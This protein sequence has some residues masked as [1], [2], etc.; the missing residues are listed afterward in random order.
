MYDSKTSLASRIVNVE[1]Q[2]DNIDEKLQGFLEMYLEDRKKILHLAVSN[3]SLNT[4]SWLT[5][6]YILI[7]PVARI[8]KGSWAQSVDIKLWLE[9]KARRHKWMN[10]N[11]KFLL[12]RIAEHY[13]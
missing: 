7:R 8:L 9:L 11:R 4:V 12:A 10:S 5:I 3:Q 13:F 2:V 1:R 6:T